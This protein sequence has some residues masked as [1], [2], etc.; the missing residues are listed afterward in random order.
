MDGMMPFPSFACLVMG[1]YVLVDWFLSIVVN[2]LQLIRL[3]PIQVLLRWYGAAKRAFA[4]SDN[5]GQLSEVARFLCS[6]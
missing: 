6:E 4:I 5:Q 2:S 1:F 3:F